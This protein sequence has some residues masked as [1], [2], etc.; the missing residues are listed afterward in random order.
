MNTSLSHW[1]VARSSMRKMDECTWCIEDPLCCKRPWISQWTTNPLVRALSVIKYMLSLPLSQD[2]RVSSCILFCNVLSN[3]VAWVFPPQPSQQKLW[4][5]TMILKCYLLL[6]VAEWCVDLF[7]TFTGFQGPLN[8][9]LDFTSCCPNQVQSRCAVPP[10]MLTSWAMSL[11][12]FLCCR[13]IVKHSVLPCAS[14]THANKASA[15]IR[16]F[17]IAHN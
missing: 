2:N 11:W 17:K 4:L 16:A 10:G 15:H 3:L 7:T 8:W 5:L 13:P 12:S 14:F 6:S 1:R 9:W